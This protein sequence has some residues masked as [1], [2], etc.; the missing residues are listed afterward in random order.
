MTS[1]PRLGLSFIHQRFEKS[2]TLSLQAHLMK[3]EL[4]AQGSDGL[5]GG[6]CAIGAD[7]G[8]TGHKGILW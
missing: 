1:V 3:T 2:T 7:N 8:V 6:T 4:L 5:T